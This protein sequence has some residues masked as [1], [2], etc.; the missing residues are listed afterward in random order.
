MLKVRKGNV[1][2]TIHENEKK[3]YLSRG[4][5]VIDKKGKIIEGTQLTLEQEV[6]K[7]RKELKDLK[8][9]KKA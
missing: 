7:L 9:T 5:S 6:K 4:F 3:T 1:A 2:Y 8:A